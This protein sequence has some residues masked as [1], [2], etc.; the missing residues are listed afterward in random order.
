M[1]N[2]V[3]EYSYLN[4][5]FLK[6]VL[7]DPLFESF[8][9]SNGSRIHSLIISDCYFT[10]GM[11]QK[12]MIHCTALKRLSLIHPRFD[13]C[14]E[15]SADDSEDMDDTFDHVSQESKYHGRLKFQLPKVDGEK[16]IR[17]RLT[18]LELREC[19]W[20]LSHHIFAILISAYPRI[21]ELILP[22]IGASSTSKIL[23]GYNYVGFQHFYQIIGQNCHQIEKLNIHMSWPLEISDEQLTDLASLPCLR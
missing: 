21:K 7:N 4:L 13:D 6:P 8:I 10:F 17:N 23:P 1:L 3:K 15:E 22:E 2:M 20:F 11:L 14:E 12:I 9:I 5:K 16:I 19:H 18:T